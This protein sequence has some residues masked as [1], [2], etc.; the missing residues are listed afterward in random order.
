MGLFGAVDGFEWGGKGG[1]WGRKG[2][3][4]HDETCDSYTLP[5]ED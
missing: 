1:G 2:H 4:Y 5:K 3:I